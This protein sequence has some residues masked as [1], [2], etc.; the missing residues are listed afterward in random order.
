[1]SILLSKAVIIMCCIIC[2]IYFRHL[3]ENLYQLCMQTVTVVIHA[4]CN[5]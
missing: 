4:E 5:S 3:S 1:V 2:T